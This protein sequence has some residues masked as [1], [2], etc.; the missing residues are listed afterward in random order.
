MHER[1]LLDGRSY[2]LSECADVANTAWA[3]AT[4][5]LTDET[6]FTALAHEAERRVSEFNSQEIANTAWA[7]ARVKQP[8]EKLFAMRSAEAGEFGSRE[9]ANTACGAAHSCRGMSLGVLLRALATATVW[10]MGEF[11]TQDLANMVWAFA[12]VGQRN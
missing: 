10:R 5:K 3:F 2:Q 9:L 4:L 1:M 7:F 6:L 8:D 11:N 12:E